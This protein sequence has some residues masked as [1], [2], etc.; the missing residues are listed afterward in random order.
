MPDERARLFVALEL[1]GAVR[2]ALIGW[3]QQAL[4][5]GPDLR[6]LAAES[7]H[8]TLCFLGWQPDNEI[9][10]IATAC[11]ALSARPAPSHTLGDARWLPPR[12]PRVL[13][14]ELLD[15]AGSL[16]ESQALLSEVLAGGGWYEPEQR[17][18]LAHVTVAR[19]ARGAR[20]PRSPLP[21]LS[22]LDFQASRVTLFRSRLYRSGAH[23]E[24]LATIELG[25]SRRP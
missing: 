5:N 19:V 1:P 15:P 4:R 10:A 16:S 13:A 9:E 8:A 20:A 23:Y 17:P 12:R 22:P 11:G 25:C 18:Y 21:P 14:V 7:L 6:P 3:R 2:D 24:A